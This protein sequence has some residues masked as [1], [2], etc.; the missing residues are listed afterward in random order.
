MSS[1]I[2]I[3]SLPKDILEKIIF[4]P[5]I[6]KECQIFFNINIPSVFNECIEKY[7]IEKYGGYDEPIMFLMYKIIHYVGLLPTKQEKITE[8]ERNILF[9]EALKKIKVENLYKEILNN[10]IKYDDIYLTPFDRVSLKGFC[11]GF[12][13]DYHHI[14]YLCPKS[15][16]KILKE[17]IKDLNNNIKNIYSFITYYHEFAGQF[18]TVYFSRI[19]SKYIINMDDDIKEKLKNN[20]MKH[21]LGKTKKDFVYCRHKRYRDE[22]WLGE[23]YDEIINNENNNFMFEVCERFISDYI[24]VLQDFQTIRVKDDEILDIIEN[25]EI[26]KSIIYK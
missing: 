13:Y 11:Y 10:V 25:Q 21:C 7:G 9:N 16:I 1:N 26:M 6:N 19:V 2:N 4:K 17:I 23:Y 18:Y 20:M 15:V 12:G 8:K 3:L 14:K 5:C 24:Y 22:Y